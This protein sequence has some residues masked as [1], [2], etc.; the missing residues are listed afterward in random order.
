M[1]KQSKLSQIT[2]VD[3]N[4]TPAVFNRKMFGGIVSSGILTNTDDY[5][6]VNVP[7][8]D[9]KIKDDIQFPNFLYESI[10]SG[11]LVSPIIL[12]YDYRLASRG[13]MEYREKTGTYTIIDGEKRVAIYNQLFNEAIE[14]NN[15]S[16]I[17]KYSSIPS[18]VL[19]INISDE[20]IEKIK[21]VTSENKSEGTSNVIS[22]ITKTK[23]TQITYCHKY[24]M[25]EVET[26][27]LVE[28]DNKYVIVQ[29]VIDEL[30]ESIYYAGL[31]QPLVVLPIIDNKTMEIKYEIQAGHKRKR[32]I[33]QLIKHAKERHFPFLANKGID[34]SNIDFNAVLESLKTTSALIIPMGAD[35]KQIE[36]VYNDTNILMR[37]MTTDDA[38][39]HISYFDELPT[40][41]TTKAEYVSFKEKKY[42]ID[43]LASVLQDKFKRLGFSDW[44]NRKAKIFLNVYYYGSDRCLEIFNDIEKYDFTRKELEW[45]ATKYKDFNERKMQDEIIEEALNDKT[46][47][48]NLMDEKI[49][50]K[51]PQKIKIRKM[52]EN[53]IKHRGAI[54]KIS[55][56]PFDFKNASMND[57]K[58]SKKIIK[59]LEEVIKDLKER[60][61]NISEN[62]INN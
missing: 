32:A 47:L 15:D 4:K 54:D 13:G 16:N 22:D 40:R 19:P 24:E 33:F 12:T 61:N 41:P 60:I 49:T 39:T 56:T 42:K 7:L 50:K 18:L 58:N 17:K 48:L 5:N 45:I 55:I 30:E 37:H 44:K 23:N 8:G 11:R 46:Y 21:K 6:Y 52:N 31:M 1:A 59:E 10:K 20:E 34:N 38:F 36:K 57:V 35:A 26:D 27:K 62:D 43:R 28:R 53:L 29:S 25:A 3:T 51:T 14:E 9:I 2:N